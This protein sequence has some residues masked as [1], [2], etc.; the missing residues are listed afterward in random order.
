MTHSLDDSSLMTHIQD[1]DEG[2]GSNDPDSPQLVID[3]EEKQ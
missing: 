2:P 1:I 3:S